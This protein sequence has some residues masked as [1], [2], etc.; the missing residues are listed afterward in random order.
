M[1]HEF[2]LKIINKHRFPK[3]YVTV[4]FGDGN[5]DLPIQQVI[6]HLPIWE[7]YRKFGIVVESCHIHHPVGPVSKK[8]FVKMLSNVYLDLFTLDIDRKG[9]Q[10]LKCRRYP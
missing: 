6:L 7:I 8:S 10:E 1:S 9:I 2:M 5:K 4:E 3:G